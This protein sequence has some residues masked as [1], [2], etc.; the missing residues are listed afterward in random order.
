[1][2]ERRSPLRIH[3][4]IVHSISQQAQRFIHKGDGSLKLTHIQLITRMAYDKLKNIALQLEEYNFIT[5]KPL[6]VTSRGL[7]FLQQ[8]E[9]LI[10]HEDRLFNNILDMDFEKI[11]ASK[12]ASI[13]HQLLDTKQVIN[14]QNAIIKELEKKDD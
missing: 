3:Y 2:K 12:S 4:E 7:L 13:Q 14:V 10:E 8:Y 6:T 5:L 11:E 9:S 1:M